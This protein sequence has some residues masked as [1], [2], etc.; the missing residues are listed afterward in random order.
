[1]CRLR[2][3][4]GDR[5]DSPQRAGLAGLSIDPARPQPG[6]DRFGDPHARLG[7]D[8]SGALRGREPAPDLSAG[9][10]TVVQHERFRRR[11]KRATHW[12]ELHGE[13]GR[14]EPWVSLRRGDLFAKDRRLEADRWGFQLF[15]LAEDPLQRR[16]LFDPADPEHTALADRLL[17]YREQ[18]IGGW[19][20]A[21]GRAAADERAE[22]ALRALGYV[23]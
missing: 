2:V 6:G 21:R 17:A 14:T 23:E 13:V 22:E 9:S 12:L 10:H 5:S 20:R 19:E 7:V 15:D 4:C 16:D 1:M 18:L 8:L 3:G 11:V